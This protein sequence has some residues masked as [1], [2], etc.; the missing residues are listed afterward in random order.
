MKKK[1]AMHKS[2]R[3]NRVIVDVYKSSSHDP[4]PPQMKKRINRRKSQTSD[5][6]YDS[7]G[8]LRSIIKKSKARK[9]EDSSARSRLRPRVIDLREKL[10]SKSEDLRIK[11]NRPKHS[12]L[13]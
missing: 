4:V 10:N 11:L 9:I 8:D 1:T 6:A 7:H 13:R 3:S 2:T 5:R 12:D